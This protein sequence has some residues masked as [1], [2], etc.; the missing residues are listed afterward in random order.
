MGRAKS[1]VP[2]T[3]MRSGVAM[4]LRLRGSARR[5]F[6]GVGGEGG[7]GH[8]IELPEDRGV[9]RELPAGLGLPKLGLELAELVLDRVPGQRAEVV[10]EE[11]PVDVVVLVLDG[12]AEELLALELDHF[13]LEIE[14]LDL[15]LLRPAD[16]RI[17]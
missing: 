15:D 12:T 16:L 10:D 11:L 8:R 9:L 2:S 5:D 1:P 4:A 3:M 17:D 14:R 13:S 6:G 7:A